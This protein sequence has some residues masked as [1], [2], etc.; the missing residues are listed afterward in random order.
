MT[1]E[2]NKAIGSINIDNGDLKGHFKDWEMDNWYNSIFDDAY[3]PRQVH[4]TNHKI[5]TNGVSSQPNM[6]VACTGNKLRI[7]D[8]Y[9]KVLTSVNKNSIVNCSVAATPTLSQ[10]KAVV[11]LYLEPSWAMFGFGKHSTLPNWVRADI[12]H[13]TT[14]TVVTVK[15]TRCLFM[16]HFWS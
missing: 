11:K 3:D 10:S 9:N 14:Q 7:G 13:I 16:P 4:S 1:A 2:P 6:Y 8:V 15:R 5:H 12:S